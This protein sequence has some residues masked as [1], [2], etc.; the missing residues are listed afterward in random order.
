M[1]KKTNINKIIKCFFMNI[2][3]LFNIFLL[4]AC[5]SDEK[6]EII[7]LVN[8]FEKQNIMVFDKDSEKQNSR[9]DIPK[10][11]FNIL[12]SK[13]YN[14][15]N[16]LINFPLEKLWETDTDQSLNDET[17]ILSEPIFISSKIY[18]IN[19]N[20]SL[21]KINSINGEILWDKVVFKN[22]EHSII[23]APS[24]SG[25]YTN[26][27]NIKIFVHS[28]NDELLS[29]DANSGKINWK[30]K[31]KLPFRGGITFFQNTL[32]MS[33]YEGNFLAINSQ[34]GEIIWTSSLGTDY[35]SVY[36]NARP[37]FAKNK[38]IVP[39][40]GGSFFILS[41]KNGEVIWT[42][43]ISS[44]SQLPKVFHSGDIVAN[45][46]YYEGVIY[47]VSQSGFTSAF[48]LETGKKL[49][50]LPIGGLETPTLS[51]KTLFV[52]GNMGVLVAINRINGRIR[53][54]KEYERYANANSYFF[55]K[56]IASYKGPTLVDSKLLLSDHHGTIKILDADK[57]VELKNLSVGKLALAPIP[58]NKKVFFLRADGKLLAYE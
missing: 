51:G 37:I 48:D 56:T 20:G 25:Q 19:S 12:N 45:P 17:P 21:L 5:S 42:E 11:N 36:T 4:N 29:I 33:D 50:T 14:L 8:V 44:H 6:N 2:F 7:K 16:S 3:F 28:G 13:S 55:D 1:N 49:W 32:F 40:T 24:I 31:H 26:E 58:V 34:N 47:L 41:A 9:L 46:V 18:L 27:N 43:N 22:L 15:T 10:N 57:G 54:V 53:W 52:N 39:G 38:I 30:K 23:G 35:S